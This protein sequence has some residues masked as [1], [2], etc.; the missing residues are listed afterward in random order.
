MD[1]FPVKYICNIFNKHKDIIGLNITE[2]LQGIKKENPGIYTVV[3]RNSD[4]LPDNPL[5]N[6]V[7]IFIDKENN[8][9]SFYNTAIIHDKN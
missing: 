2:A 5:K 1:C 9:T 8:V 3:Y 4:T 7:Y 6:T